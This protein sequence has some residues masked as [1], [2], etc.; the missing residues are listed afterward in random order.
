[1]TSNAGTISGA[2]A[3]SGVAYGAFARTFMNVTNASGATISGTA[4][5]TGGGTGLY[6]DNSYIGITN[7]GSITGWGAASS[8]GA[9][10]QSLLT[11]T[12]GLRLKGQL[13]EQVGY[14]LGLGGEFDLMHKASPYAGSSVLP[15]LESF[16]LPFAAASNH[17]HAVASAGLVYQIDRT[18][19]LTGDVHLRSQAFSSQMAA[20]I[21][22]GYQAA[23]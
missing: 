6:T 2:T 4:T 21:V 14:Q 10:A 15:G 20:T 18:Q 7:S 9:Y 23:F 11:A 8:Y 22:A 13:S 5:G 1:V 19:R 12:A 3:G 17:F 16:A